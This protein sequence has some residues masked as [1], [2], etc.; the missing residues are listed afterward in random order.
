MPAVSV[1]TTIGIIIVS[2]VVGFI[3]YYIVSPLPKEKRKRQ[4]EEMISLLI[5]FVIFIWVGK[6]IL[7]VTIFISDP[8]A[9]LAYP[10][11]SHAFY[12][13]SLFIVLNIGYKMKRHAFNAH[14]IF[15]SFVPV[16]LFASFIYEFIQIVWQGDTLSWGY[17]GLLM[18]LLIVFILI[19]DRASSEIIAYSLFIGWT[20]GQLIFALSTPYTAVFGYMMAPWFLIVLLMFFSSLLIYN[21]RKKES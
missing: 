11:N 1:L 5:N 19:H 9:I 10:S 2:F 20:V 8:L 18:V 14:S 3:F 17:L 16:F 15:V 6:V 21:Y 12:M 4:I 13:A 7:N